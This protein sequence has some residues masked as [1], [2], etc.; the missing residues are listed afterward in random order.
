M[1]WDGS[2]AWKMIHALALAPLDSAV[3]SL[4]EL[5]MNKVVCRSCK[6]KS[7]IYLINHPPVTT[8]PRSLGVWIWEW[9]N[10][11]NQH[12]V[13]PPKPAM[14]WADAVKTH[15]WPAEWLTD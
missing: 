3:E 9:H 8:S 12:E 10:H 11:V 6:R 15:G 13:T 2:L 1:S 7:F 4:V 14:A 5:V